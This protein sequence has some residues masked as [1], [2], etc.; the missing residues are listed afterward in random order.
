MATTPWLCSW[1][2]CLSSCRPVDVTVVSYRLCLVSAAIL[3]VVSHVASLLVFV[4]H[5]VTPHFQESKEA[6]W[7]RC[8]QYAQIVTFQC[9][10]LCECSVGVI[11]FHLFSCW[12]ILAERKSS[13][14]PV[15]RTSGHFSL[16]SQYM[17]ERLN[18]FKLFTGSVAH[19]YG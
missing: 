16:L 6:F 10:L 12:S 9:M 17:T 8:G 5:L 1:H 19:C 18:G 3:L 7:S 13:L 15:R 11:C 2:W 4:I 14:N